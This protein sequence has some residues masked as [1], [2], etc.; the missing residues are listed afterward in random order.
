MVPTGQPGASDLTSFG[1]AA[2]HPMAPCWSWQAPATDK[3]AT[4]TVAR[5][6][7]A[8][9]TE[10]GRV[11]AVTFTS[12]AAEMSTHI[13][14]SPDGPKPPHW[15]G[16]FYCRPMKAINVACAGEGPAWRDPVKLICHPLAKFKDGLIAPE[17]APARVERI[18]VAADRSGRA[19]DACRLRGAAQIYVAYRRRGRKGNSADF[20]ESVAAAGARR[21]KWAE[22]FD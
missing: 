20:G 12:K 7:R 19:I 6:I 21:R 4:L 8:S 22:R 5:R 3:T 11:L 14:A 18:I 9:G 10:P 17:E 15:I 16:T 1:S 2:P 13:C